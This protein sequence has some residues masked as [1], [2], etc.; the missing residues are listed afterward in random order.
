[1][2]PLLRATHSCF[3]KQHKHVFVGDTGWGER[4][5]DWEDNG[6]Q[7]TDNGRAGSTVRLL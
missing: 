4:K 7:T 3:Y 2:P 6:Q 5:C 1:M